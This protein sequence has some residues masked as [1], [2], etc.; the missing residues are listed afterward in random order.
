VGPMEIDPTERLKIA[1]ALY[2]SRKIVNADET[3]HP[4]EVELVH[5]AFPF[6]TLE[7]LGFV[8]K[9]GTKLTPMFKGAAREA[10][11][12]LPNRLTVPE[13]EDFI[14]WFRQVCEADGIVDEREEELVRKAQQILGLK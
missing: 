1:F 2:V 5:K 8:E 9:G 6:K 13:K 4:D 14:A 10:I 3:V 11:E 12:V 7:K